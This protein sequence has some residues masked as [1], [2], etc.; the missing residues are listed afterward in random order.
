MF[1]FDSFNHIIF[2]IM[3]FHISVFFEETITDSRVNN[4]VRVGT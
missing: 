2:K 3:H 4:S 1:I